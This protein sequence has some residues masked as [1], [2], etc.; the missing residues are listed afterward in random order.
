MSM[1]ERSNGDPAQAGQRGFS[2]IELIIFIVVVGVGIAGILSVMNVSVKSSADPMLRKQALALAESILEEVMLKD[3][4]NPTGGY[5]GADRSQFD[6][7]SDYHGIDE[8]LSATGPIFLDMDTTLYG[9]RVQ[10]GVVA[11]TVSG[12][13][14]K[15][16]TVTT[17]RSDQSVQLVG[18]RASY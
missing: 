16:V 17:S 8:T 4:A 15:K 1:T 11:Q 18:Y 3:Y 2:L 12:Q 13:T 6:D 7:V 14:L 9:F 10:I 5:S